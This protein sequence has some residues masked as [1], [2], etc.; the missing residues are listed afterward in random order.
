MEKKFTKSVEEHL[1]AA[2]RSSLETSEN[3]LLRPHGKLWG[4]DVFSWVNPHPGMIANTIHSFP[5]EVI[6]MGNE[7]DMLATL[8]ED[9]SLCANLNAAIV[10][11]KAQ[12]TFRPEWTKQINNYMCAENLNDAL[13]LLK[14]LKASKRVL[15]FTVSGP[16]QTENK[17]QFENYVKLV[18]VK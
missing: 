4:M 17:T 1:L 14:T 18:Q 5:F 11:D 13:E 3:G 7:N 15:L 9:D 10:Y 16:E 6:W 2:R 12:F 8:C